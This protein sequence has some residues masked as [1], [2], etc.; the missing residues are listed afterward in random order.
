MIPFQLL[1]QAERELELAR[2]W[3]DEQRYGLG[4]VFFDAYEDAVRYAREFPD[5][6]TELGSS[7]RKFPLQ[8]FPFYLVTSVVD[9]TLVVIA[10]AHAKRKPGY[11]LQRIQ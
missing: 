9:E 3:Y 5:A 6:G 11:W 10:V 4:L 1:R 8:G 2:Q 7:V